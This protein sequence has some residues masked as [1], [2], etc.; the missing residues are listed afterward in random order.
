MY[1]AER[2]LAILKK[3]HAEAAG[4]QI[5]TL[6]AKWQLLGVGFLGREVRQSPLPSPFRSDIE[7]LY[8][9]IQGGDV[10]LGADALMAGSPVPLA[11]SNTFMPGFGRAYSTSASVTSRPMMADFA[12][13]CS[14]AIRRYELPHC[15]LELAF[16]SK[17]SPGISRINL[18]L[19][20]REIRENPWLVL[21]ALLCDASSCGSF[22][23]GQLR[24]LQAL[25]GL[26]QPLQI[27]EFAGLLGE[28]VNYE[29]DIVEQN[30]FRLLVAFDVGGVLPGLLQA[31]FDLVRD[32]LDLSRIGPAADHKVIGKRSR[33]LLQF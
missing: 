29:I 5:E 7:E 25:G 14:E 20:I 26:P 22:G 24:W 4:Y 13:H 27:V 10:T 16:M 15:G 9:Q 3:H 28:H 6:I 21:G 33:S 31:F 30:P 32:R 12:F 17:A 1:F 8:A 23:F 19:I 11:R 2:L 18:D